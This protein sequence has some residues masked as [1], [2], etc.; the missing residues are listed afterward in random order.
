METAGS[1]NHAIG[2]LEGLR[3]LDEVSSSEQAALAARLSRSAGTPDGRRSPVDEPSEDD[4][5]DDDSAGID[6]RADRLRR[7]SDDR[8]H[9][10]HEHESGERCPA[11]DD[12]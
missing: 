8:H 1:V 5:E 2:Q 10:L 3:H 11:D 6:E 7:K 4:P 12:D 9:R